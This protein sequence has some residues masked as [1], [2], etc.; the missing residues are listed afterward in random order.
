MRRVWS[1]R[2][3]RQFDMTNQ[4]YLF[5]TAVQLESEGFYPVELN[6]WRNGDEL[7]LPLYQGLMVRNFDHRA[8][9]VL[10]NPANVHN[11]YVSKRTTGKEHAEPGFLPGVVYWVPADRVSQDFPSFDGVDLG[12][13][14]HYTA[15]RCTYHGC[16][17]H[18]VERC[19]LYASHAT[20][21]RGYLSRVGGGL[22]TVNT[23]QLL[24]RL[25]RETKTAGSKHESCIVE[26]LPVIAPAND[27]E[28]RR[29]TATPR[30]RP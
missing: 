2:H 6:R 27:Y 22:L 16:H 21:N 4:S 19:K 18:P 9:S 3:H 24:F 14:A 30:P 7:Y 17:H 8:G 15:N 1:L 13:P 23:H 5:R 29:M 25:H 20:A 10:I 28:L 26:Q 11:P 12:L